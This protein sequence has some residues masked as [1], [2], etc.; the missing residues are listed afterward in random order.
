MCSPDMGLPF[1]DSS[2]STASQ[3]F[4]FIAKSS[5]ATGC[6]PSIYSDGQ[7]SRIGHALPL[8]SVLKNPFKVVKGPPC[9][10]APLL[11]IQMRSRSYFQIYLDSCRQF[12]YKIELI[13][14]IRIRSSRLVLFIWRSSTSRT[15]SDH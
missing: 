2:S 11:A 12:W 6:I 3:E 14:C 5:P 8:P 15:Q 10:Q 7:V 1:F 4:Q 9:L 13:E